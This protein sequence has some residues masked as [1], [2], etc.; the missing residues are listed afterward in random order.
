M[1]VM[2]RDAVGVGGKL[3]FGMIVRAGVMFMRLVDEFNLCPAA[4]Q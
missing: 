1:P 2:S 3:G 4:V